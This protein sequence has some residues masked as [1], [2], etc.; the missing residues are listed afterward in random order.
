[1]DDPLN[2]AR[3]LSK[4][5]SSDACEV[6]SIQADART[7][8]HSPSSCP[9]D[10]S[11]TYGMIDRSEKSGSDHGQ[12]LW[13][14]RVNGTVV[15]VAGTTMTELGMWN[16]YYRFSPESGG[17]GHASIVA[18]E[19]VKN[20]RLAAPGAPVVARILDNNPSSS[21]V[22]VRAGLSLRW[23]GPVGKAADRLIFADRELDEELIA[24]LSS[25]G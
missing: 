16:L 17:R 6:H 19:A 25:L 18:A 8:T 15:G 2:D 14:V 21:K 12:G 7:W 11:D 23:R 5:H 4:L 13:T 24:T 22:A 9:T 1:M 20:A 3:I 10:I